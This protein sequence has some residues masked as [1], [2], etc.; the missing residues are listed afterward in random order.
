MTQ[1]KAAGL[2]SRKTNELNREKE[3]EEE[4]AYGRAN[5]RIAKRQG[6]VYT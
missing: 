3:K 2:E 4:E 6:R 1:T 5:V